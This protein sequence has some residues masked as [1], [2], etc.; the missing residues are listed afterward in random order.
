MV[1]DRVD[2]GR[3]IIIARASGRVETDRGRSEEYRSELSE[4]LGTDSTTI[5][6]VSRER[7]INQEAGTGERR[8]WNDRWDQWNETRSVSSAVLFP[9]AAGTHVFENMFEFR[10]AFWAVR[11]AVRSGRE[12]LPEFSFFCIFIDRYNAWHIF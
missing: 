2:T 5:L 4:L 6:W 9:A 10:P 11:G 7:L 3:D 1:F 8:R 12:Y